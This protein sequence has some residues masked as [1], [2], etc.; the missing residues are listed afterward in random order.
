MAYQ[1]QLLLFFFLRGFPH[2]NPTNN[3]SR[4]EQAGSPQLRKYTRRPVEEVR[5]PWRGG[6]RWRSWRRGPPRRSS[7]PRPPSPPP[8]PPRRQMVST[9]RPSRGS[10]RATRVTS[11]RRRGG[12][13]RRRRGRPRPYA[14]RGLRSPH[15]LNSHGF[16]SLTCGPTMLWTQMSVTLKRDEWGRQ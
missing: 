16:E 9:S 14:R 6:S 7:A 2:Q 1:L 5:L 4:A 12:A 8:M 3:S 10:G 11:P 15:Y 13:M